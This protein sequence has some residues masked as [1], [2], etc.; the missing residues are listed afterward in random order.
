MLMLQSIFNLDSFPLFFSFPFMAAVGTVGLV[1]LG[2]KYLYHSHSCPATRIPM[3]DAS[4]QTECVTHDINENEEVQ[5]TPSFMVDASTQTALILMNDASTTTTT[6]T[7][8]TQTDVVEKG[9]VEIAVSKL[10]YYNTKSDI[11][12]AIIYSQ[13]LNRLPSHPDWRTKLGL[14]YGDELVA[15]VQS[16]EQSLASTS[17]Q[18]AQIPD[19]QL[20][21]VVEETFDADIVQEGILQRWSRRVASAFTTHASSVT[22]ISSLGRDSLVGV[23]DSVSNVAEDTD[24]SSSSS[25]ALDIH[26]PSRHSCEC[27]IA[28]TAPLFIPNAE[29]AMRMNE[30][31]T[32]FALIHGNDS[33]HV[34][35]HA[36]T[37]S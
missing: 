34:V 13:Y 20:L 31:G 4:T 21:S 9:D 27:S 8:Y 22:G 37:C 23:S 5:A 18:T 2:G 24:A 29:M 7:A 25:S 17:G 11:N 19:S 12:C 10:S 6:T 30:R 15:Y 16:R 32:R 35:G 3:K 36:P 33:I 28:S 26:A 14:M 1:W